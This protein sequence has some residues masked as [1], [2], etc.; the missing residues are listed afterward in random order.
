M[1]KPHVLVLGGNFS[2]L[3]AAQKIREYA[4]DTVDITLIDRKNYLLFVPNISSEVL[5]Y[6]RNPALTMHMDIV[7]PLEEDDIYFIQGEVKGFDVDRQ[8]VEYVPTERPGA[9][10]ETIH[11]DYVVFA[12]GNRLAYDDIEGFAEYGQT[13]SDTYYGEKFRRY[14]RNDYKGGPIA[15]GSDF[16]HQGTMT[17][18]LVPMAAAACEGPPVEMVFSM[19]SWLKDHGLGNPDKITVFT[20]GDTIAE[21]AGLGNV[22][23]ILKFAAGAGV[24]Y[25][26]KAQG[27]RR[28][29]KDGVELKDGTSI[30]AELKIIFPDWQ[31]H[32]FMKNTPIVDDQGFVLTDMTMRH[33]TYKN[34]FACGDAAAVV[35]PKL[36]YL[37]HITGDMVAKQI[38]MDMGRMEPAKANIP[39]HFIVN[40]LGDM[41]DKK[42]FFIKSDTW[43]GGKM[44]QLKVGS[45]VVY[46]LK[47]QYKEMFFR[48]KGKVPDWGIPLA[49]FM[50]N[51]L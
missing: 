17:Q 41:G 43:Y 46:L 51:N 7:K 34:V 16:F 21:D 39:P 13:V 12:L 40:C 11:Y 4:R 22:A 45:H 1:A 37:A 32:E 5:D 49:D 48:T 8:T 18:D 29:T 23:S 30:E 24:H 6:D 36:G 47:A 19:A 9:A 27:I 31:P 50:A 35:V 25:K 33:P 28:L 2:G 26:N 20:P 38:A 3:G 10:A 15:I 42:A 14:L 44:E